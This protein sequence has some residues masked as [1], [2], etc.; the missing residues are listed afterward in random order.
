MDSMEKD[1][2]S[3]TP[4]LRGHVRVG[5]VLQYNFLVIII[6]SHGGHGEHGVGHS[7]E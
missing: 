3:A 2:T 5:R 1:F 7:I 6:T 4:M